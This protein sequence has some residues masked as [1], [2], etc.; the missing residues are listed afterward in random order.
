MACKT[1]S[2]AQIAPATCLI[3]PTQPRKGGNC[4][5][6]TYSWWCERSRRIYGW[7]FYRTVND[8][9]NPTAKFFSAFSVWRMSSVLLGIDS[10][11]CSCPALLYAARYNRFGHTKTLPFDGS[12]QHSLL[13]HSLQADTAHASGG[14]LMA[15]QRCSWG[16]RRTH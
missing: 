10:W 13:S 14:S 11:H 1:L 7:K 4:S 5:D 2:S 3:T 15:S 6:K 8:A 9:P 12:I 16:S